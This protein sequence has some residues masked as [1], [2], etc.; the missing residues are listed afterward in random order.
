MGTGLALAIASQGVSSLF[1]THESVMSVVN[2]LD[3]EVARV[4]SPR[5]TRHPFAEKQCCGTNKTRAIVKVAATLIR[6]RGPPQVRW[7]PRNR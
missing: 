6:E 4:G 5:R 3:H 2:G 7:R 1:R